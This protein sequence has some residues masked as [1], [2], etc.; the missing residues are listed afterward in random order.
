MGFINTMG[1]ALTDAAIF[2]AHAG[3]AKMDA[4]GY[5]YERNKFLSGTATVTSPAGKRYRTHVPQSNRDYPAYCNCPQ[6]LEHRICKHQVW[7]QEKFAEERE[8]DRQADEMT[9]NLDN[10]D[11]FFGVDKIAL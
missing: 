7:V 4:Q 3:A 1:R 11:F 6:A 10:A 8:A 5:R 9:A 2:T